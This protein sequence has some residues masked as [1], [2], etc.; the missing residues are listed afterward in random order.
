MVC[1][2]NFIGYLFITV[3]KFKLQSS[4]YVTVLWANINSCVIT[5]KYI[6]NSIQNYVVCNK[7]LSASRGLNPPDSLTRGFAPG[8]HREGAKPLDP[9]YR[10]AEN[11]PS[12]LI[13][14]HIVTENALI[15]TLPIVRITDRP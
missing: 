9:R 10:L 6:Q 1:V 3:S 7:I 11:F 2:M 12:P 15:K 14:G 4:I 5:Q 8:P 13:L